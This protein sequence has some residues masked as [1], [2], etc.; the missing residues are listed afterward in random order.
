MNWL[1]ITHRG[2][3]L[4]YYAKTKSHFL[5][6]KIKEVNYVKFNQF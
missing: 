6:S 5:K 3:Y 1:I 4:K 2:K